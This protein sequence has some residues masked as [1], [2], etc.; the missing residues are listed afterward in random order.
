[1]K[2]KFITLEG[3]EGVGKTTNVKYVQGLISGAGHSVIVT[4]E[5]GGTPL[6]ERLRDIV[7]HHDNEK[8]PGMAE[9]LIMFAGRSLHLENRIRPALEAGSWVLCDRFTDA[10]FAY[11]GGGRGEDAERIETLETWVQG[12]LQPDL[13]LLLDAD[14]KVGLARTEK[15][16]E[17]DRFERE[18]MD[19]F[20][21]VRQAYLA[22]AARFPERMVIIDAGRPLDQVQAD[23]RNVM[24]KVI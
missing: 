19:F 23:I 10:T 9:L 8:V 14:P 11:Q 24:K 6:A 22:R 15:R 1:M 20:S 16:G 2:G 5:P 13:T 4:R 17:Q 12:G 18:R 21:R 3:I 7:L